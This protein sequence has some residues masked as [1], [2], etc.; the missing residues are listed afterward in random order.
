LIDLK[1]FKIAR[2][3]T[4][5][6]LSLPCLFVTAVTAAASSSPYHI[7]VSLVVTALK[8]LHADHAAAIGAA[9]VTLYY[10]IAMLK[11]LRADLLTYFLG[12]WETY[13]FGQVLLINVMPPLPNFCQPTGKCIFFQLLNSKHLLILLVLNFRII[14]FNFLTT[15]IIFL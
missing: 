10:Q 6:T 14:A 15:A 12:G 9:L 2:V 1:V 4:A 7:F 13:H 8:A 11:Y 5:K 3:R